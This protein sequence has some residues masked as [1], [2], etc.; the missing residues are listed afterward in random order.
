MRIKKPYSFS[1][2][3]DHPPIRRISK[4]ATVRALTEHD[5]TLPENHLKLSE[6]A[7]LSKLSKLHE[8]WIPEMTE[9]DLEC[10]KRYPIFN[11][12]SEDVIE[13]AKLN[14]IDITGM[15][16][17]DVCHALNEQ[18][19]PII[20][21]S[22]SDVKNAGLDEAEGRRKKGC[23]RTKGILRNAKGCFCKNKKAKRISSKR[24]AR[25]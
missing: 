19:V 23:R 2:F 11:M 6:F 7:K 4:Y 14:N 25:K 18:H 8:D 16:K 17:I 22:R 21:P 3:V 24:S 10:A 13:L 15:S 20:K 5:Q 12:S 1:P 9:A